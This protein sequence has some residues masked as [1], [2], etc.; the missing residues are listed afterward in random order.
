MDFDHSYTA[1]SSTLEEKILKLKKRVHSLHEGLRH[2]KKNIKNMKDLIANFKLKANIADQQAKVLKY[3]FSGATLELFTNQ[4]MNPDKGSK[5][6]HQHSTEMKQLA[7]TLHYYSPKAYDFVHKM[8]SLLHP[9]SIHTW[10]GSVD[11]E[12]G[13]LTN[14]V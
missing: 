4:M 8:F 12:P 9:D 2:R 7:M 3:N 11:C 6:A 14:V 5:H 13:Y 10:A 1:E